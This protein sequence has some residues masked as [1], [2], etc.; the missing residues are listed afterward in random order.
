MNKKYKHLAKNTILISIGTFGSKTISFFLL[1]IFTRVLTKDAYGK[2]DFFSTTVSLL[3]S[4]LSFE[5][6]AAV[7]RFPSDSEDEESKNFFSSSYVILVFSTVVL[8]AFFPLLSKISAFFSEIKYYIL[9]SI[10]LSIATSINKNYLRAKEKMIVFA[11]S[12]IINTISFAILGIVLVSIYKKGVIGYLQSN[13]LALV[14]TNVYLIFAGKLYKQFSYRYISLKTLNEMI[15][16]SLPFVPNDLSWWI[17]NVSDR[18]LLIYFIGFSATG[19]YGVSYKFM[20]LLSILNTIFYQA[21]QISAVKQYED[22]DRDKFYSTVF[23]YL[24]TTLIVILLLFSVFMKPFVRIMVGSEFEKAWEYLPFLMLGSL[25]QA[26]SSFYGVGYIASKESKGAFTTSV[27]GALVNLA[28]NIAFIPL[29]GIQAAAISTMVAFLVM[30][31]LR[32]KQTKKY[33]KLNVDWKILGLNISLVTISLFSN[34]I[35]IGIY[36]QILS[37]IFFIL[38][39]FDYT[40]S[41]FKLFLHFLGN[42]KTNKN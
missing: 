42:M 27:Y 13:L 16:Y 41:L 1:P 21:W 19:L 5:I 36:I 40:S 11:I 29:I 28:I 15:K 10:I 37:V 2:I 18:Y 7:F 3:V 32:L 8:L 33:F 23:Y 12:D 24:S 38:I 34:F 22:A 14:I 25:F 20:T 39:N 17:M 9:F 35:N 30:W 31:L 4:L 6:A 26:F